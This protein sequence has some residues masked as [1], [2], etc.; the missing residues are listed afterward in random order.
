[1]GFRLNLRLF[2][3]ADM[4]RL[5]RV[6]VAKEHDFRPWVSPVAVFDVEGEPVVEGLHTDSAAIPGDKGDNSLCGDMGKDGGVEKKFVV[7][8]GRP[9]TAENGYFLVA[10]R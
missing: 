7:A 9:L 6:G 10:T 2:V 1:M 5:S 4:F 8:E 3:A